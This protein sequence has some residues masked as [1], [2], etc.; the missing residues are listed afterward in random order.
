[1][2]LSSSVGWGEGIVL[3]QGVLFSLY[4]E[5]QRFAAQTGGSQR[6]D[7]KVRRDRG[8]RGGRLELGAHVPEGRIPLLHRPGE[9]IA[10]AGPYGMEPGFHRGC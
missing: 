4:K 6:E 9:P 2:I 7:G 8:V 10:E 5:I 1:M 3:I